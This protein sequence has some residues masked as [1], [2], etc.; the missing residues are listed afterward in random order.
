MCEQGKGHG[1]AALERLKQLALDTGRS[2]ELIAGADEPQLQ[3]RLNRF[4]ERHGFKRQDD[5]EHPTY[6][7][8]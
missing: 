6:K 4:Y 5:D 3:P 7:F 1:S 8:W 2:V